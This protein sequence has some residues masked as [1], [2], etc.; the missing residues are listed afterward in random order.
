MPEPAAATRPSPGRGA[1]AVT[2]SAPGKLILMGEHAVV[3]GAP[4]LV[5]AIDLRLRT[6]VAAAGG[7]GP[8]R[9][10]L[11]LCEYGRR[12]VA[13]WNDLRGLA[14]AARTRWGRYASLPSRRALRAVSDG[15]EPAFLA[16]VAL[17]ETALL[18]P[19]LAD[20]ALRVEVS[21]GLPIGRG[22]GS[23]AALAVSLVAALLAWLDEA[24]DAGVVERLAL[25]VERRQHGHPS[26]V[27]GAT[28]LRGGLLWAEPSGDGAPPPTE[29]LPALPRHLDRFRV[30][31]TGRPAQGTGEVVA[32][33]RRRLQ[34]DGGRRV[35]AMAS[36]TRRFRDAL[37]REDGATDVADAVRGY[38]RHLEALGVV[39][40]PVR[41]LVRRVEAGGGAAKVSGAG[42]LDDGSGAGAGMLLVYHEDPGRMAATDALAG[43]PRLS[44]ELGGPGL[45]VQWRP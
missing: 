44:L 14:A 26:G 20:E 2:A 31:D 37:D 41:E 12:E 22:M 30:Y 24:P 42:A 11:A 40:A 38:Q 23:S 29:P 35:E 25:D 34:G 1:T 32:A 4:A 28:V 6:R 36:L 43:L 15:D 18:R 5:A 10:D 8:G 13:S 17:G 16:R 9:V 33:V 19:A 27:D 39:P 21:G 3:H 7:D 45:E